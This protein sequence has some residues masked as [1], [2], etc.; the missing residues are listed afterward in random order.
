MS[1][2]RLSFTSRQNKNN[3][4]SACR[5]TLLSPPQLAYCYMRVS[6]YCIL[7]CMCPHANTCT[8]SALCMSPVRPSFT[9]RDPSSSALLQVFFFPHYFSFCI[10]LP[11]VPSSPP[12]T[13]GS[14]LYCWSF[15]PPIFLV[16]C[17]QDVS[18]S[19]SSLLQVILILLHMYT[20]TH[21]YTHIHIHTHTHTHTYKHTHTHT[22]T[23]TCTH[24]HVYIYTHTHIYIYT[25]VSYIHTY[26]YTQATMCWCFQ[27]MCV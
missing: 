4:P 20:H 15:F 17:L 9:S 3:R 11:S 27:R 8:C 7:L 23:H 21:T 5:M 6:A 16:A 24:I 12:G 19:R 25:Y 1:P 14:Q 10:C 22:H 18:L 2:V 26:I 13:C